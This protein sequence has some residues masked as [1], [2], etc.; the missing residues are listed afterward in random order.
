LS[1]WRRAAPVRG[2]G[3]L[4]PAAT[5]HLAVKR[6]DRSRAQ[7]MNI[8]TNHLRELIERTKEGFWFKYVGGGYFRDKNIPQGKK[9][10]LRHGEEIIDEFCQEL[11]KRATP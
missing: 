2:F 11:I 6:L 10:E 5:A 3:R 4:W 7:F 8:D 9:A 1:E